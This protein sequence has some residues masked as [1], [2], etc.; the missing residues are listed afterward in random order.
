MTD[1][2]MTELQSGEG[3]ENFSLSSNDYAHSLVITGMLIHEGDASSYEITEIVIP[4]LS[5]YCDY[6]IVG[7]DNAGNNWITEL[8]LHIIIP[9]GVEF[10]NEHAF[11]TCRFVA[12]ITLSSTLK[13]IGRYAFNSCTN[14]TEVI[15]NNDNLYIADDAFY[16]TSIEI[17]S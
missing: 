17:T 10:I 9:E 7:I 1:E 15:F 6:S 2:F 14:L 5:E 16:N 11:G 4:T 3:F 8:P 13:I 12:K